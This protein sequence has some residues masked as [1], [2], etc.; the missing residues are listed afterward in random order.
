MS[1]SVLFNIQFVKEKLEEKLNE[2]IGEYNHIHGNLYPYQDKP[3]EE[4][5]KLTILE[6]SLLLYQSENL[7]NEINEIQDMITK[8]KEVLDNIPVVKKT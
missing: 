7:K 6:S 3:K 5:H 2:K 8:L 4:N 1:E